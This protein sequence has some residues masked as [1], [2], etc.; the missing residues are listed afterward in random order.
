[1]S[2]TFF[3]VVFYCHTIKGAIMRA[4]KVKSSGESVSFYGQKTLED[5]FYRIQK[6]GTKRARDMKLKETDIKRLVFEDR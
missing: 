3:Y 6:Y 1:M 4:K 5:E 2:K